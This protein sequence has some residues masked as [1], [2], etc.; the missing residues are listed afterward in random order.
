MIPVLFITYNRLDYTKQAMKAL[1]YSDCGKIYIIDNNSS[2]GTREWLLEQHWNN[3]RVMI[4]FN[5][6]N[7]GIAGAMNQF[8]E[9]TRHFAYVGKVDND[10][11]VPDNWA[12]VLLKKCVDHDI[13]IVQAKHPIISQTFAAGFD[14]WMKTMKAEPKD[15][16]IFY[17][18][19][20]GGSGII[21]NR[22]KITSIP[23]TDWLLYGWRQYQRENIKLKKAFCTAVQI[24][25]LDTD[26]YGVDYSK[27]PEY[28]IETKRL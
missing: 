22:K 23:T 17:H 27:Y 14:A 16:S 12:S 6:E 18:H 20:V 8:L 5:E 15:K 4:L 19:F 26:E 21:F 25:L 24:E 10:T 3:E 13:D 11:I 9:I 1:L 7:K 2:D 28:Y